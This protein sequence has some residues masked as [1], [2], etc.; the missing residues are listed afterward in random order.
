MKLSLSNLPKTWLIDLDGVIVKH[1]GYL[2]GEDELLPGAL[3]FIQNIPA[4]DIIIFL[5]ARE[6]KWKEKTE[7]FLKKKAIRYDHLIFGL[8]YGERVLI[9]DKKPSGLKTAYAINLK[10][11]EGLRNLF[12][13]ISK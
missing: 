4:K 10:R 13:E 2:S 9:N 3:N 12:V 8:P 1:N 5:T 11:D 6:S 7:K